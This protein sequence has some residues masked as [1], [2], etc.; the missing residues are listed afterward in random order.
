MKK[1]DQKYYGVFVKLM[2]NP[3]MYLMA[4]NAG[5]DFVFF[6]NEHSVFSKSALHDLMLFGN[7]IGIPSFIRVNELS[8]REISQALDNG[9][10]GVM[11]PM[12]ETRQQAQVL[13]DMSKYPPM[14]KR[15]YSSGANTNYGPSGGH[16]ENME[17]LNRN[18][19]AIAQIETKTGVDNA[20]D[21]ISVEGIDAIIVG[22][23]DLSISLGNIGNIMDEQ[24]LKAID[25]VIG[26][27]EKYNKPF[28]I[29]GSNQILK[30]YHH[31]LNYFVSAIDMNILRDGFN[32]AVETYRAMED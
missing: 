15:G 20:E 26:L 8:R 19:V 32:K 23:V 29:I 22:P 5:L 18:V 30:H 12:I 21:I 16:R 11:V 1:I 9:A 2:T 24:E 3:A 10:T 17:L 31:H 13:A 7:N 25:K 14:G 6:D 27:C 28:G 4:K